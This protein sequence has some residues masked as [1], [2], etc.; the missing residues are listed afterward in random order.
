MENVALIV[1][2][3][4]R[5]F[6][7]S[8][9]TKILRF[10]EKQIQL[11]DGNYSTFEEAHKR[12]QA[13]RAELAA[14]V[15]DKRAVVENQVKT[16]EQTAV[17]TN[18]DKLMKQ[19]QSR[20]TKLGLAGTQTGAYNRVGL[21]GVGG[22]K[23]KAS[24]GDDFGAEA[25][26]QTEAKEAETKLKLKSAVPLGNESAMLQCQEV[27]VG[28]DA[29]R[30]LIGKFDLDLRMESRVGILGVNGSGKTTLL[31]VLTKELEPLKGAVYQQQRV[32]IGFFNQHQADALPLNV[33]GIEALQERFPEAH[34]HEI[35]S[36][37]GSFGMGK[38]ATQPIVTLS[39]GEKVRVAL[40][41]VT[42]RPPHILLLD[43]P[44][45][46][47]DLQTVEALG[48]ALQEFQGGIV[49]ASHDRRLLKEVC[50]DFY[51]VQGQKLKK[52]A[53]AD[54]VK[55]VRSGTAAK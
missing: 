11:H 52:T 45:N 19:V 7:D 14:R 17:K 44:T 26:M 37:L 15:A 23:W 38:Q 31:K 40:A 25:F 34:E 5:A 24:Y 32:I 6:L 27:V 48:K 43:E 2:S 4:D 10:F 39:G 30:P 50:A 18:N 29:K 16:M 46:H 55:A 8:V 9:C 35:R 3:H 36:H 53:L 12:D 21:E 47:L 33:C 49:I 1:V 13:H 28:Y 22:T 20:K 42:F 41:A 54:F 51:S